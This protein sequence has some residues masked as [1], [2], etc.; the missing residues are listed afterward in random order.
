VD[1]VSVLAGKQCPPRGATESCWS[2]HPGRGGFATWS[3][4]KLSNFFLEVATA[5]YVPW[6]GSREMTLTQMD[7]HGILWIDAAKAVGALRTARWPVTIG[8]WL[9]VNARCIA[10]K[11]RDFLLQPVDRSILTGMFAHACDRSVTLRRPI[12]AQHKSKLDT[13][14]AGIVA[15]ACFARTSS[16]SFLGV[17]EMDG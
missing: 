8:P 17:V 1:C 12:F 15:L 9:G 13:Q 5:P 11:S 3:F 14:R 2:R 4:W 16:G 10:C 6:S 7:M